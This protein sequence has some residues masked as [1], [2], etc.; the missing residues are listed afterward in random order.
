MTHREN[1][2]WSVHTDILYSPYS[3]MVTY[4]SKKKKKGCDKTD[5]WMRSVGV[6]TQATTMSHHSSTALRRTLQSS[7]G[8]KPLAPA[9]KASW[10][11]TAWKRY[12]G[13]HSQPSN[14]ALWGTQQTGL[15]FHTQA[16]ALMD[17][18]LC[19]TMQSN[20]T[21]TMDSTEVWLEIAGLS[22]TAPYFHVH[23]V[24][25]FMNI[26]LMFT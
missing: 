2:G 15:A 10:M 21:D 8:T 12:L 26:N 22:F 20:R 16:A 11:T 23:A 19:V 25:H 24:L 4:C 17:N 5:A 3:K 6:W 1:T 7:V 14:T 9:V 13:H 18:W